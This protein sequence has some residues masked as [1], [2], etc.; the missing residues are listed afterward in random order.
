MQYRKLWIALG[1]VMLISFAVLGSVGY[2]AINSAPPVPNKVVT[3]DGQLLFTG[4]TIR[5]GQN[6]W[7][8]F[9]QHRLSPAGI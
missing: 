6:V 2:K 4:E 3:A 5:N 9:A 7:L 8:D 1:F